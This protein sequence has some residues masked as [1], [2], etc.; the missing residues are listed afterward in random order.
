MAEGTDVDRSQ[1]IAHFQ[2]NYIVK[3]TTQTIEV[4]FPWYYLAHAGAN[5]Y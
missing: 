3:Y 4:T 1:V 2:V 5:W